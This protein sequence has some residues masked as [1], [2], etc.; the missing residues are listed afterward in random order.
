MRTLLSSRF[1]CLSL[2]SGLL[3]W[4]LEA[5]VS[6]RAFQYR[7]SEPGL[8]IWEGPV[9]LA[10]LLSCFICGLAFCSMEVRSKTLTVFW[11]TVSCGPVL[12]ALVPV[13][14][15]PTSEY[16]I[17]IHQSHRI[18]E[19][20]KDGELVE[21]LPI[22][23]GASE[24]DK[25][26]MGDYK[27]PLGQFQIIDKSP[28]A[29]HKWLGLNYPNHEDAWRGRKEAKLTWIEFWYLTVENRNG[30]IPYGGSPLGG[31]IGIHGGGAQKDWTMGCVALANRDVDR[32]FS[33]VPLG[34]SVHILP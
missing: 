24:G 10:L 13:Y 16:T 4:G 21:T 7:Y 33:L 31:A 34:T 27:T 19:L 30:R 25:Q 23:L 17:T 28:S 20:S 26:V 2:V 32:L 22:A 5:A 9:S 15:L 14:T 29:F 1:G 8:W 6:L 18:L 3:F 12:L 11:L